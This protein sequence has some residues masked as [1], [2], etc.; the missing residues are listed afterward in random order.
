MEP[1]SRLA[2][3]VV[4]VAT[5]PV[6]DAHGRV[7]FVKNMGSWRLPGELPNAPTITETMETEA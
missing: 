4:M 2:R 7:P 6:T 3:R 5:A 1:D